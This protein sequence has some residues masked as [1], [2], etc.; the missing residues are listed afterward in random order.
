M[1]A[2]SCHL[3]FR[4]D[5][6]GGNLS[7]WP[8]FSK[9]TK[10][11]HRTPSLR[12]PR[13]RCN[14]TNRTSLHEPLDGIRPVG[15]DF[16]DVV[17]VQAFSWESADDARGDHGSD[18]SWYGQ[19]RMAIPLMRDYHVTHVWLPPASQSLDRAGYM[20][21]SLYDLDSGY[22]TY[23]E[24][25]DLNR[26]LCASSLRPVADIVMN[27]RCPDGQDENGT[28]NRYLDEL[29]HPGATLQWDSSAI[30][31]DDPA[32]PGAGDR[33]T[34]KDYPDAPDIDHQNPMVVEGLTDWL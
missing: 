33:D 1:S 31:S 4:G 21:Q 3:R 24:L 28:Y 30:A 9:I 26:E 12:P 13:S 8:K 6:R 23:E 14:V 5:G 17:L 34:G 29:D 25:R 7:S 2:I 16:R 20:P 18:T 32:W 27:H 22:G 15:I 19:I 10:S 11:K